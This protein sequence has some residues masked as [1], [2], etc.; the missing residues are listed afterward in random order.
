MFRL[1]AEAV[2]VETKAVAGTGAVEEIQEAEVAFE[3]GVV[4]RHRAAEVT[5]IAVARRPFRHPACRLQ[6][7]VLLA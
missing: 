4:E 5:E 6:R 3:A 1:P 7:L 2:A